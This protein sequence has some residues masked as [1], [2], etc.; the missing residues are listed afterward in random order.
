MTQLYARFNVG[1]A[2]V[3]IMETAS[4]KHS[5][6]YLEAHVLGFMTLKQRR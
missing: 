3:A 6:Q 2:D 1:H 5:L 4:K